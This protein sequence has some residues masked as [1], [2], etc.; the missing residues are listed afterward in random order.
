MA[1]LITFIQYLIEMNSLTLI[2]SSRDY[3]TINI[4]FEIFTLLYFIMVMKRIELW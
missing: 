4:L 1:K 3:Y 2:N